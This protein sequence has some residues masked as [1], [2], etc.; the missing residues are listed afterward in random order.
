MAW[1]SRC[2]P[3]MLG[4]QNIRVVPKIISVNKKALLKKTR[5]RYFPRLNITEL[6]DLKKLDRQAFGASM[7]IPL[8]TTRL[9]FYN[10][11]N[12]IDH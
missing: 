9:Y 4:I 7:T 12:I 6:L 1:G 8:V 3:C 5:L 10:N 2:S 11:G